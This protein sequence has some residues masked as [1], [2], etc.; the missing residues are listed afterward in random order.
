MKVSLTSLPVLD[1]GLSWI[2]PQPLAMIPTISAGESTQEEGLL[3]ERKMKK[4]RG[5]FT[6]ILRTGF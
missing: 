3:A 4:G 1:F 5:T 6:G 2:L